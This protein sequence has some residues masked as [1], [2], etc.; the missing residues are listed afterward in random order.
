[1][2][3][4]TLFHVDFEEHLKGGDRGFYSNDLKFRLYTLHLFRSSS[5]LRMFVKDLLAMP[6]LPWEGDYNPSV[7]N[8][9]MITQFQSIHA[10]VPMCNG[11]FEWVVLGSPLEAASSAIAV[12]N[13]YKYVIGSLVIEWSTHHIRLWYNLP[14]ILPA[15]TSA[16]LP[17]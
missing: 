6:F 11:H 15:T 14:K 16:T 8:S 3:Q 9:G 17:C 7:F 5:A 2:F 12:D 13:K 10:S 4:K 1:M